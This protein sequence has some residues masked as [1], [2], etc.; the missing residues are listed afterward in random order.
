MWSWIFPKRCPACKK[1][2]NHQQLLCDVCEGHWPCLSSNACTRCLWPFEVGNISHLCGDCLLHASAFDRVIA[3]GFY[4]SILKELIL[5]F[6]F[7]G[8]EHLS[9]FFIEKITSDFSAIDVVIPIPVHIKKLRKRGY[10]QSAVLAKKIAQKYSKPWNPFVLKKIKETPA[11]SELR[12]H[13]R[14]NNLKNVFM[15]EDPQAVLQK[16]VLLVDDVY[17]TGTTVR[18]A[19]KQLIKKGAKSVSVFVIARAK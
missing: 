9:R 14:R 5:R 8:E 11:Q 4:E 1:F 13:E 17:T 12:G 10:N 3:L 7:E 18:E 2:L 6:K 15:V 16:R 19:S